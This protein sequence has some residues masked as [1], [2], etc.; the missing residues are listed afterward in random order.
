L[1]NYTNSFE[2]NK[3]IEV[4]M[5]LKKRKDFGYQFKKTK[6]VHPLKARSCPALLPRLELWRLWGRQRSMRLSTEH[7]E[8]S[9]GQMLCWP[10]LGVVL[11]KP[12]LPPS[13]N[14]VAAVSGCLKH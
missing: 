2:T 1:I 8:G 5:Y 10:Q 4:K 12:A 13:L 14:T 7:P 3:I 6:R 11:G 9:G